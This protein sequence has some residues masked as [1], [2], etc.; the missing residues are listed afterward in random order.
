M[1]LTLGTFDGPFEDV[2]DASYYW[3]Y[4]EVNIQPVELCM[5]KDRPLSLNK[6]LELGR[7]QHVLDHKC[8]HSFD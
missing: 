1:I 6:Q 4:F 5:K 7:L 3:P 2:N 8:L